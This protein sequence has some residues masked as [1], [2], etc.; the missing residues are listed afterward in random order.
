[1]LRAR[2]ER[3]WPDLVEGLEAVHPGRSAEVGARLVAL[4]AEAFARRP[5]RLHRRDLER[6]LRPDW[7]QDPGMVGY[8]AYTERF[9]G[10]L[11]GV[12][13][14]VPY[15]EELGVRYLHLMPLLRTREGD[16]D[17]GYAVVDHREVR[18]DLGTTQD[19]A[20]LADVL[21]DHDM[22]L[23]L[24]L[25]LNHVAREHDW[26]VRA[27]AGD[28]R[29]RAYFHVFPDRTEPDAYERTLPEVF[30]DF[31]P[32]SFTWDD[33]LD[34]WVWT[35]FNSF[36]WD[37]DWGNPD[38]LAELVGVVLHLAN[39]G[40]D[41]LR[42]DA[43]AFLWKRLGTDCQ[44]QPEVHA[45]T[46]VLRAVTRI[47]CPSVA[48]KAEAIVA[49]AQLLAYLGQGRHTG[50]VS[51]LAYHNS[52]MVQV[53]SMLA[54]RDVRLAVQALG[55]LPP[56]PSTATWVTYLRCHDDIGW[57][58]SDEDAAAVGLSGHAHRAFLADWFTGGF[59][60]S[61][62]R[63]LTFQLNPVTGDRRTS[64][65]A[66]SLVGLE[67]ARTPAEV[68]G[69][70]AALRLAHAVVLGWGGVPVI[71]SGDEL[72]QPNDP[73]WAGE[74]GHEDDNRWAH[75]PRLDPDRVA[76][77]HDPATVPGRVF[78]DLRHLVRTRSA[79]P[80]LHASVATVLGPVD[81]PGVLVT[82]RDHPLGRFA[83]VY[84]VTPGERTWPGWRVRDLGLASAVDALTGSAPSWDAEHDLVRL[85]PHAVLWLVPEEAAR[86]AV[87][88]AAAVPVPPS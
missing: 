79:L 9:A 12:A 25:V 69:A 22:S 24:D 2:L 41:V 17:G 4:A 32:G 47:A 26:A 70:L 83:G 33:E 37:L 36:Q 56:A 34:G 52:L 13:A 81:D 67:A 82:L 6:M 8:A 84:N 86:E 85:P 88:H 80:H 73:H 38:V 44:G 27:R 28:P 45:L 59:P 61:P 3:W 66:A 65:T 57:A 21:H 58:V 76:A 19:L 50:K 43:V 1:M 20:D 23:V 30:P 68:D 60:G 51:D 75:R 42:L 39:L 55:S 87:A 35:T 72:A 16:S 5:D 64:G 7:L 11:H 49:P 62:A 54:T 71:W 15:L 78:G 18:P 14:R 31:A 63:G 10:D 74:P 48:F 29:Y 40:V 46:Q 77:R 53:W